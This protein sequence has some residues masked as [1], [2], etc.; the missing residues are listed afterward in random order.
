MSLL[1]SWNWCFFLSPWMLKIFEEDIWFRLPNWDIV[2][3]V[4]VSLVLLGKGGGGLE[5]AVLLERKGWMGWIDWRGGIGGREPP[6]STTWAEN[7]IIT[8]YTEKCPSL[9]YAYSLACGTYYTVHSEM[10][11]FVPRRLFFA[12]PQ[13]IAITLSPIYYQ[14]KQRFTTRK[15]QEEHGPDVM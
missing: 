7:G 4:P 9:V 11:V 2:S 10:K 15:N 8:E 12:A 1:E 6:H 3:S 5:G 14:K 13:R